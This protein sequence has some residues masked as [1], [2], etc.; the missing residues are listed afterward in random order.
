MSFPTQPPPWPTAEEEEQGAVGGF[1]PD[2]GIFEVHVYFCDT[3]RL[4]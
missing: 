1:D 3:L 2:E 4:T